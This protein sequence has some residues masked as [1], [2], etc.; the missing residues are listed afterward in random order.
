MTSKVF[1]TLEEQVEI[2]ESKGLVVKDVEKAKDILLRENYFF[3]N[4]YRHSS[5]LQPSYILPAKIRANP[6]KKS[7]FCLNQK[8]Y[9]LLLHFLLT[10]YNLLVLFDY[11]LLIYLHNLKTYL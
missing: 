7:H 11:F 2:L 3:L 5:V 6:D 1:K 8:A 9:L 10:M 4:G